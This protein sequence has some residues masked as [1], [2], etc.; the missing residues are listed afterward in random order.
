MT[1]RN[2][3]ATSKPVKSKPRSTSTVQLTILWLEQLKSLY[4]K[5]EFSKFVFS[6]QGK[7]PAE[8]QK[9]FQQFVQR[10]QPADLSGPGWKAGSERLDVGTLG[11]TS[12]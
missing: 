7:S 3:S 11:A 8:L 6:N 1:R 5:Q 10:T 2:L 4:L 9:A 12:K